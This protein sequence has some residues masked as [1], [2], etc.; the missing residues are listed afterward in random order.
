[1]YDLYYWATPNGHKVTML[2]EELAVS[3][4]IFPINIG[5]DE[6]QG[7][8]FRTHAPNGKIPALVDHTPVGGGAPISLFESGAILIHL[9]EKHGR[10]L[11]ET[12]A[13]RA[14]AL[15]WLFWQMSG[16]GPMAGQAGHFKNFAPEPM[17]YPL[18]RY[19]DETRRLYGLLDARL[20][21]REFITGDAY[22]IADIAC[23]PW[24]RAHD[25]PG[26]ALDD[27][28]HLRRWTNQIAR[29]PATMRA[30]AKGAEIKKAAAETKQ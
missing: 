12:P 18:T 21:D 28:T 2:L 5:R 27:F 26:V 9:A 30:Y 7:A 17:A 8:E 10:F 3:Y 23:H 6:Q 15:S 24:V 19:Q 14:D 11:P 4:A 13:A 20:A 29:R 16:L 1:M 25:Y 22:S